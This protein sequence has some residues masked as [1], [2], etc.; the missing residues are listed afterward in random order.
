M[1]LEWHCFLCYKA[2][3][4]KGANS[5]SLL[6]KNGRVINPKTKVDAVM[7]ILVED[8]IITNMAESIDNSA[9]H[10]VD[11]NNMWVVPGLI[12]VHVHLREPGFEYKE[13]IET[14]TKSAAAGGFTTI[15]AMPNTN[16]VIDNEILVEHVKIKAEQ[17]GVVNVLPIGSITKGQRGEELA[18]IGQ[19]VKAGICAISEDGHTVMNASLMNMALKYAKMFNIPVMS[20]CEDKTMASGAMNAGN[21]SAL[22]GLKGIAREAEEV[23]TARDIILARGV[24]AALHICHVSTEGA[25]QLVREAKNRNEQITAE[26]CPHHFALTDEAVKDYDTNTKMNP[27]LRTQKDVDSIKKA[28][29]ENVIE[30]IA[31]DH[32]PHHTDD[33]NCEYEKAAFGIVGLETA[34]PLCMTELIHGGIL[35][36][37][38]LIEKLTVNPA[39]LINLD[40]GSLEVGKVADI[41][42]IDP[43][44]EFTIDVSKFHSKGKNSPFDGYRA[45]GRVKRTI[46]SGKIVF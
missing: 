22:I 8:G 39:K 19:M 14:G 35:S 40:K 45:K 1:L 28:L 31:T 29:K 13:T 7:D 21:V 5:M 20:H 15:C 11:A 44:E 24:G 30:I 9:D 26:V 34:I 33:K 2:D 27:P 17:T 46:V 41:T 38:E 16:P 36:P 10:T 12:D 43:S 6:I 37:T 25:V 42:I 4:W 3:A 18:N 32:A 23:I